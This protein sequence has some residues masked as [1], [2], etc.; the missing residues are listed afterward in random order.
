MGIQLDEY[1]DTVSA[2]QLN[3]KELGSIVQQ[4]LDK[5]KLEIVRDVSH[6]FSPA[7]ITL[8]VKEK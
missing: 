4:L 1:K 5:F 3:L 8:T 7:R 2:S 6:D